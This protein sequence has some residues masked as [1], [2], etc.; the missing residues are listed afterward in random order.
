MAALSKCGEAVAEKFHCDINFL[1]ELN[2][3]ITE[4]LKEGDQ[5][6]VPN[7]KPFELSEVKALSRVRMQPV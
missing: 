7:V 6:T 2:P 3:T 5:V 1:K 4:K